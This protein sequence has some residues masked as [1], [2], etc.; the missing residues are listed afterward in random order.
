MS[1][2][3]LMPTYSEVQL[4]M[5]DDSPEAWSKLIDRLLASPHYGERWARHWLDVARYSDTRGYRFGGR[6]RIYAY[7]YTYRDYVVRA[8]N[9][10]LPFD[11]FVIQQLAAD[12]LNWV[13]INGLWR[14]WGFWRWVGVFWIGRMKSLMTG[15]TLSPAA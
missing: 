3:G 2:T 14:P 6:D 8:F 12:H 13:K 11:Q 10:D 7:A 1:L 4:F 5:A 15:L 9:E